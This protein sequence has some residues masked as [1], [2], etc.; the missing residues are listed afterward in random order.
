M[1][2]GMMA[3]SGCQPSPPAYRFDSGDLNYYLD[4]ATAIEYPDSQ[5]QSLDE[6]LSQQAPITVTDANFDSFWDLTLEEVVAIA[7]QNSKVIR[8]FG[9]PGLNGGRV[10]PGADSIIGNGANTASLYNV[11]IR[12]SEPGLINT[13]GAIPNPAALVTNGGLEANQGV[14]A[15][16]A[17]FDAQLTSQLNWTTTDQPRNVFPDPNNP[18]RA[19][20]PLVFVQ[21]QVTWQT[22]VAKRTA[23]GTQ[24]F[25]RNVTS[26][27]KNN[28]PATVQPLEEFFQVALEAEFRQPLLRGRGAFINRMPVVISR[29]QTDQEIANLEAVL[30]NK[31]TNIE[32][33]YWDLQRA[34]RDLET[35]KTGRDAALDTWRM[36]NENFKAGRVAVQD[37]T[38]AREQ[39]YFFRAQVETAWHDLLQAESN[40]RWLMGVASTDGRMIRPVDEPVKAWVAFDWAQSLD[41][42]L[43]YRPEL[44]QEQWEIKKR[45]LAVAYAKNSLL[46]SLNVTGL[47]RYL[48]LGD[49]L[50]EYG[51]S[52]PPF[53]GEGSGAYNG[54]WDGNY[55]EGVL[56]IE[57]GMPVGFRRE[58]ANVRNAQLKLAEQIAVLEDME[59]DVARELSDAVRALDLQ[60]ELIQTNFNRWLASTQEVEARLERWKAGQDPISFTLDAQRRRAQGEAEYYRSL[61]E[62]NKLIALIHRRK[63]TIL[64]YN[65][66]FFSEGPWSQKAY[67]DASENARRRGA[68]HHLDYGWT[69]PDVISQGSVT[70]TVSDGY[71]HLG[72]GTE[73]YYDEWGGEIVPEATLDGWIPGGVPADPGSDDGAP[74]EELPVPEAAPS[75]STQY[76]LVPP[77]GASLPVSGQGRS[78]SQPGQSSANSARQ[79]MTSTAA[80][81]N[82]SQ[83]HANLGGRRL[84]RKPAVGNRAVIRHIGAPQPIN[85]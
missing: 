59:L 48:G 12:E 77:G 75:D 71:Q 4:Q 58:L 85:Q 65:S 62:Y 26:Y 28:V 43:F 15:A 50:V 27:T 80:M 11:A 61:A 7:L 84:R 3:L 21:D 81:R 34:Y 35:S 83:R 78:W 1:A 33:R 37:E 54:L 31:V 69:R 38:E 74:L 39:Y 46:P 9:T 36:I 24:L 70:P 23:T 5:H 19:I 42:A 10:A 68:S 52:I 60:Y 76:R 73:Y 47:Y 18:L 72:S 16:L 25:F 41:E 56:G 64:A 44:R 79:L 20:T 49:N 13:P 57:F 29:I 2:I 63:G 53:P 30:Q 82:D 66:V 22:E 45:E 14:E 51:S 67:H 55:Q 32:I 17:D 40:L 8:G 6:V